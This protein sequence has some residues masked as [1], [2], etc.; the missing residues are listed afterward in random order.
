MQM[1]N[2]NSPDGQITDCRPESKPKLRSV[3]NGYSVRRSHLDEL[4]GP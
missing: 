4:I 2:L 3:G 1:S